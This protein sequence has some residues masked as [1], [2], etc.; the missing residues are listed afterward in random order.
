LRDL[1]L[2]LGADAARLDADV[3]RPELEERVKK[4]TEEARG[5]KFR[6]TPTFVVG[7]VSIRGAAPVE[8]FEDAVNQA[9]GSGKAATGKGAKPEA[10]KECDDCREIK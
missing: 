8:V 2:S 1:A 4:D 6:G 7:G 10:K 9:Q 3:K 5:F